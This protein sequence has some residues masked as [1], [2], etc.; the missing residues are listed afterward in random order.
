[1]GVLSVHHP[2]V[3]EFAA[4]KSRTD[5]LRNFNLSVA[6]TDEFMQALA[7][8]GEYV[9]TNPRTGEE[10]ARKW[11]QDVFDLMEST[12]GSGEPA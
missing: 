11:A 8:G 9:L 4:V 1:M 2:D 3:L 6:V 5:L 7:E 10:V 12:G